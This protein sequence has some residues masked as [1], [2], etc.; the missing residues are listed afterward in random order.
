MLHEVGL[1]QIHYA[2]KQWPNAQIFASCH[3]NNRASICS[4]EKLQAAYIGSIN[5]AKRGP[6][7][8]YQVAK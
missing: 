4:V 2:S 1:A 5:H 3:P 7:R 8:I 6:R